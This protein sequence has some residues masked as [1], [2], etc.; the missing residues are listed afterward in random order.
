MNIH[1][2]FKHFII[3][4]YTVQNVL[5]IFCKYINWLISKQLFYPNMNVLICK[6]CKIQVT[7]K[8]EIIIIYALLLSNIINYFIYN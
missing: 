3:Y 4:I 7:G 1:A 5:A 8:K 2:Y 6:L